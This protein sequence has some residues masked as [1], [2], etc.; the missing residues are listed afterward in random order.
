MF[1]SRKKLL[2]RSAGFT[3][4]ELL[5]AIAIVAVLTA[6]GVVSFRDSS[7]RARDS[8]RQADINQVRSALELYRSANVGSGYPT[9]NFSAMIGTLRTNGYISDPLPSDPSNTGTYIYTYTAVGTT[10]CLCANLE[11][12][13]GNRVSASCTAATTPNPTFYCLTQP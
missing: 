2:S 9:G 10:Y 1:F 11:S 4:I 12:Q 8:K 13:P 5:V 7:L 3:L 6:I